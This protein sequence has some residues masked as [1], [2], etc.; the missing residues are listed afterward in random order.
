MQ[1]STAAESA[2]QPN[3][4]AVLTRPLP[5]TTAATKTAAEAEEAASLADAFPS[6]LRMTQQS[7]NVLKTLN[8]AALCVKRSTSVKLDEDGDESDGKEADDKPAAVTTQ[9][10]IFTNAAVPN[11]GNQFAHPTG[12]YI[13]QT[14]PSGRIIMVQQGAQGNTPHQAGFE[15][16]LQDRTAG[17]VPAFVVE[18][19]QYRP[20]ASLS[21][22]STTEGNYI[23]GAPQSYQRMTRPDVV[24]V[25]VPVQVPVQGRTSATSLQA[26]HGMVTGDIALPPQT[27]SST[28][29]QTTQP[30]MQ[31]FGQ[32][33]RHPIESYGRNHQSRQAVVDGTPKQVSKQQMLYKMAQQGFFPGGLPTAESMFLPGFPFNDGGA[34]KKKKNK[35]T[36]TSEE[37]GGK[38]GVERRRRSLPQVRCQEQQTDEEQIQAGRTQDDHA[39]RLEVT[40][41][42][43]ST[44]EHPED[45]TN[46]L[47]VE[48]IVR[49]SILGSKVSTYESSTQEKNPAGGLGFAREGRGDTPSKVSVAGR[50][51]TKKRILLIV[52]SVAVAAM[53]LLLAFAVHNNVAEASTLPASSPSTNGQR[54]MRQQA[55]V[56][57]SKLAGLRK[58]KEAYWNL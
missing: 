16:A 58:K 22:S 5:A 42:S 6:P 15:I 27:W 50:P 53:L 56:E 30:I 23:L 48:Q 38:T 8:S 34:K 9:I 49:S 7:G 33:T 57:Y 31:P 46:Q 43:Q 37:S 11:G 28:C 41:A 52:G 47:D 35:E 51:G 18:G 10:N 24:F 12:P 2:A 36:S 45:E 40:L 19:T 21:A 29:Q 39:I 20:G 25:Q 3:V 17:S 55:F 44:D 26:V 54:I 13:P 1:E 4:P 14:S 32:S